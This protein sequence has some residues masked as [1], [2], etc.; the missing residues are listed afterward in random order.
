VHLN[1]CKNEK[2]KK[3]R[4]YQRHRER[5]KEDIRRSMNTDRERHVYKLAKKEIDRKKERIM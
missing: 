1:I 2:K 3:D 5:R 4:D